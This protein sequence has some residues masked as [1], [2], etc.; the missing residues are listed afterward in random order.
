[1]NSRLIVSSL[2]SLTLFTACAGRTQSL[3][4]SAPP[5]PPKVSTNA[6][7]VV[8]EGSSYTSVA[9]YFI[10]Q[11][12]VTWE[13]GLNGAS[14]GN[15][16]YQLSGNYKVTPYTQENV[17]I[18]S[19]TVDDINGSCINALNYYSSKL[20]G[21]VYLAAFAA[22]N[23]TSGNHSIISTANGGVVWLFPGF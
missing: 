18:T 11:N 12:D 8:P 4:S 1:M 15:S 6:P 14:S 16:Y 10:H 9:C 20:S 3:A 13:W 2:L 7:P 17:F 23:N 21:Y 5:R 19:D 22:N